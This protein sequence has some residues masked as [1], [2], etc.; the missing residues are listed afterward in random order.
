MVLLA[1]AR[2]CI[3][4]SNKWIPQPRNYFPPTH[5]VIYTQTRR[6]YDPTQHHLHNTHTQNPPPC[7]HQKSAQ[8]SSQ[9]APCTL[10]PHLLR[11]RYRCRLKRPAQTRL[12]AALYPTTPTEVPKLPIGRH[13]TSPPSLRVQRYESVQYW[14][15]SSMVALA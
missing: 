14:L 3:A 2:H 1:K 8:K 9:P 4:R 7:L 15:G 10:H 5:Q 13:A 11:A 6:D 12:V